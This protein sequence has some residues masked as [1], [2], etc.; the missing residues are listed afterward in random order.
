MANAR[1]VVNAKN[2]KKDENRP[3]PEQPPQQN[4]IKAVIATGAGYNVVER[5][6]GK[7]EVQQGTLSARNNNPG[8]LRYLGKEPLP[9]NAMARDN[10]GFLIFKD[11]QS[12][13]HAVIQQIT[14]TT[15]NTRLARHPDDTLDY[16]AGKVYA[17]KTL[18]QA[19]AAWAN[20]LNP[21]TGTVENN[22]ELYQTR[23]LAAVGGVDKKM[24]EYS[25]EELE[26]IY[27]AIKKEEHFSAIKTTEVT[28]ERAEQIARDG[29]LHPPAQ[30][31]GNV[32]EPKPSQSVK[33]LSEFAHAKDS[34]IRNVE[35]DMA[36]QGQ[37]PDQLPPAPPPA[38]NPLLDEGI[39]P[40]I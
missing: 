34:V 19:I 36:K 23:A 7:I 10:N 35:A 18:S 13:K 25:P 9:W 22:T 15:G 1:D 32:A 20:K 4:T 16:G 24:K 37:T 40:S 14:A 27:Q 21:N 30:T 12:G 29:Y 11:Y 5:P 6:D 17:E 8:N 28:R 3:G 26:K 39:T 31:K 38:T 2:S 33:A